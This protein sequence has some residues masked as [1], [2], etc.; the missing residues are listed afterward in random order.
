M[1]CGNS[2][3]MP[4]QDIDSSN[5]YLLVFQY[6]SVFYKFLMAL[7]FVKDHPPLPKTRFMCEAPVEFGGD[8]AGLD[9]I[10]SRSPA[11]M[12]CHAYVFEV[13]D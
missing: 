9:L 10:N 3:A 12:S 11:I 13:F 7:F 6:I 4:A 5:T 2:D 8:C 1:F